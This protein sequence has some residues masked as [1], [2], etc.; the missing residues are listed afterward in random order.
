MSKMFEWASSTMWSSPTVWFITAGII[1]L[2][3][4]LGIMFKLVLG[5]KI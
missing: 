4:F 2:I 1:V 3:L 5:R